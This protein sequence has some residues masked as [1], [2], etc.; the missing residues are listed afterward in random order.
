MTSPAPTDIKFCGACDPQVQLILL[1]QGAQTLE[2]V[3]VGGLR[4]RKQVSEHAL[5]PVH[6][7]PTVAFAQN[8]EMGTYSWRR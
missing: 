6:L 2:R 4:R 3:G 8:L 7:L 1:L 5:S